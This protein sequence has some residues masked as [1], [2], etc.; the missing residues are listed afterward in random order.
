MNA[1]G[2]GVLV[3]E[4]E[5][6]S[7][8]LGALE[9]AS[10][11]EDVSELDIFAG[12]EGFEDGPLFVEHAEDVFDAGEDF[13]GGFEVVGFDLVDGGFEFVYDE[14]HPEF[15][16]LVLD[17]EE[18]FVVVDGIAEGVLGREEFVEAEVAGIVESVFELG[19]DGGF[20]LSAGHG[21]EVTL[22]CRSVR[23]RVRL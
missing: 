15:A 9:P 11:A 22:F 6:D 19:L 12:G 16:G 18:H 14:F 21:W 17:D 10:V 8:V 23:F 13:E 4:E 1:E 20:E 2:V 5:F 3:A 7:S